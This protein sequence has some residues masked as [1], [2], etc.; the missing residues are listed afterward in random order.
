MNE[1]AAKALRRAAR[2]EDVASG[3]MTAASR[4]RRL[5]GKATKSLWESLNHRERGQWSRRWPATRAKLKRSTRRALF[6]MFGAE[7]ACYPR[8]QHDDR[9]D[10]LATGR[11]S[12]AN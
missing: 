6:Q 11:T 10:L 5:P 12:Y 2:A 9:L 3:S 8:G 4:S 1:R 7:L